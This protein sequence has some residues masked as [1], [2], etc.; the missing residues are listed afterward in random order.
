MRTG[1]KTAIARLPRPERCGD[2]HDKP[3]RWSV[4]S[5]VPGQEKAEFQKFATR[6]DAELYARIRRRSASFNEALKAY[7]AA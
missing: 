2:W 4:T 5:T 7:V 3:L 6:K 1:I